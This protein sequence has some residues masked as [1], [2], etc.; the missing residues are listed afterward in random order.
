MKKTLNKQNL[1]TLGF[2]PS[3]SKMDQF[4]KVF[5]ISKYHPISSYAIYVVLSFPPLQNQ[6]AVVSNR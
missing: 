6:T 4:S 3:D 5:E 2:C 1:N